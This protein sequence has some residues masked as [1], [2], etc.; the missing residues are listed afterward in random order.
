[1]KKVILVLLS[2]TM[3]GQG[4]NL[5]LQNVHNRLLAENRLTE[6]Q[7][8][9]S[10]FYKESGSASCTY[11]IFKLTLFLKYGFVADNYVIA[12][13][14]EASDRKSFVLEFRNDAE[15][16]KGFFKVCVYYDPNRFGE[17]K[18][19]QFSDSKS[20]SDISKYYSAE[21]VFVKLKAL[22]IL[23]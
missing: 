14:G 6:K 10:V 23:K 12:F 22:G 9:E 18:E 17:E 21:E 5:Y 20:D 4:V 16:D 19:Y 15:K 3:I 7:L 1:M 2:V 11:S 8:I 13:L